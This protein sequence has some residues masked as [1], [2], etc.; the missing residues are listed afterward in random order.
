MKTYQV[1]LLMV[2]LL[3]KLEGSGRG[4]KDNLD[5]NQEIVQNHRERLILTEVKEIITHDSRVR[6]DSN[7]FKTLN[8]NSCREIVYL[9]VTRTN[10]Y[11]KNFSDK[12][13]FYKKVLHDINLEYLLSPFSS[14]RI[15]ALIITQIRF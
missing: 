6:V 8:D 15:E 9:L 12:K 7:G 5:F 10:R 2:L 14:G 13:S 4:R 11:C 1:F 3:Q